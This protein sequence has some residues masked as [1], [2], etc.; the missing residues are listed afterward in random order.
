MTQLSRYIF[1]QLAPP[2]ALSAA[3]L[4]GLVW[5]LYALRLL[6]SVGV[7]SQSLSI[8]VQLL[9]YTAPSILVLILPP[10]LFIALLYTLHRLFF[11]NEAAVMFAAGMSRA[12]FMRPILLTAAGTAFLTLILNLYGLPWS[13]HALRLK[14]FQL[15]T[16][17]ITSAMLNAGSFTNPVAGVTLFVRRHD[18]EG[19]IH[20]ILIQDGR[21][22]DNPVTYAAETGA[23]LHGGGADARLVMFNGQIHHYDRSAERRRPAERRRSTERRRSGAEQEPSG[24]SGLTLLSFDKY[25]YDISRLIP[26]RGIGDL[27]RRELYPGELLR[28]GAGLSPGERRARL[29]LFHDRTA[30]P[31]Y[32]LAYAMLALAVLLAGEINRRGYGLR[33]AR[34]AAAAA[35]LRLLGYIASS[36][37]VRSPA[38]LPLLYILPLGACLLAALAISR[39]PAAGPDWRRL[40]FV[41]PAAE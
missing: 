20:G 39:A 34:A 24:N 12:A 16:E 19:T 10:A 8:Y 7:S 25:S 13:Q 18:F 15:R 28:D 14:T 26:D 21:D 2:F 31:L 30:A 17:I 11:D 29:A 4:L 41:R 37:V 32:C 23:L 36:L 38:A 33:I 3:I 35:G 40:F 1:S 9:L 27:R 22:P 5:L 6:D